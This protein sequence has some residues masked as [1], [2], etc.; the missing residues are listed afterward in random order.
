LLALALGFAG[1][2]GV[3]ARGV[4]IRAVD[5]REVDPEEVEA[6]EV[7]A[8][9]VEAWEVEAEET[10]VWET[11]IWGVKIRPGSSNKANR[12]LLVTANSKAGASVCLFR[13]RSVSL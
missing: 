1:V 3:D 11:E 5:I 10:E 2:F 7:E 6:S 9:E 4:E 12:R 8:W 13:I